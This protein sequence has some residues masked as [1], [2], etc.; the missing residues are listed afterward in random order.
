MDVPRTL[1]VTNDYPPRVGGI[2]RTLEALVKELPAER[3]SVF[4]P[5][6]DEAVGFDRSVAYEVLRQPERFLW[7][8]PDVGRRV[9]A[10]VEA[11]GAEVV[12]FGA[13]YPLA[14]LGPGLAARGTP[15][16]AAAHG[17]EYWLSVAPGSHALMRY[18]TSKASRV[19]VMCSEFI[20][21]TVRTAVPRRVPV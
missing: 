14:L 1:L 9:Q 3:V 17:F 13:T 10:V 21:R 12:L 16:L 7:P 11:S 5:D 4:C 19:P 15:Y 6:W 2:Q 18:A 20:A 8:T